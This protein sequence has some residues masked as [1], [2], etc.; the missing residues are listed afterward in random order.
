MAFSREQAN[1]IKDILSHYPY[2]FLVFGSRAKG[3]YKTY[4][5]LDLC[6]QVDI[7]D[8]VI[9]ALLDDFEQSDLPF[10][11]DMVAW[12]RCSP[13]FQQTIAA[14]LVPIETLLY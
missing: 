8:V 4:S 12:K 1:I 2:P 11:V 14:D 9:S 5:D 10:K 6:Y 7:P 3:T 13:E